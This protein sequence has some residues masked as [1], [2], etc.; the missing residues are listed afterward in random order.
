MIGSLSLTGQVVDFGNGKILLETAS[1]VGYVVNVSNTIKNELFLKK[2]GTLF[3]YTALKKDTIELF[4]LIDKESYYAFL[5]LISISGIGPKKALTI[6]EKIPV[7]T[8][9][10]SV[11]KEDKE[12]LITLGLSK[13]E[14]QKIIIDLEKRIDLKKTKGS[15]G[16]IVSA[17]VALGYTNKEI[18][19]LLKENKIEGKTPDEQIQNALK[20]MRNN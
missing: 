15:N 8:L 6:L 18:N 11:E 4:G 1:G 17:L 16:I 3:T 7:N 14:A 9:F 20:A 2:T 10:E 13:K 12:T 5:L 19:T